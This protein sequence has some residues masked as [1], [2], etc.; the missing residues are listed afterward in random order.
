MTRNCRVCG[1]LLVVGENVTQE[2]IDHPDYICRSCHREYERERLHHTGQKQP[3][4]KNRHCSAFLGVHIAERVLYHVFKHIEKMPYGNPGFDFICGGGYKIDV[5]SSCRYVREHHADCW[6]FGIKKNQTAEYFLCL[7][8]DNR[9]SLNPEHI[10]LIPAEDINNHI[11]ISIA[12]TTL[13]KWDHYKL[14]V[15][16]VSACCNVL[17]GV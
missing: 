3:M 5:K 7:A 12:E 10:W 11:N 2:R 17:K 8:F 4:D 16:K 6:M 14:D 1:V 15:G 13:I 9:E